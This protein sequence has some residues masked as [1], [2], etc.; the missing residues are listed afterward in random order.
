MIFVFTR[1]GTECQ[2]LFIL[3]FSVTIFTL[4]LVFR[5]SCRL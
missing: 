1:M 5:N 2:D 3:Y 4:T